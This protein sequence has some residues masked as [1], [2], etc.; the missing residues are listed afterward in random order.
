MDEIE[1]I[2]LLPRT[3]LLANRRTSSG[4]WSPERCDGG[5]TWRLGRAPAG[6]SLLSTVCAARRR[7]VLSFQIV[8]FG[9]SAPALYVGVEQ[10]AERPELME[11][12]SVINIRTR[13]PLQGVVG[14]P[15]TV[16]MRTP[17]NSP[18]LP[19]IDEHVI[20]PGPG[21]RDVVVEVLGE[22]EDWGEVEIWASLMA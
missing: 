6:R 20:E 10:S 19:R 8:A 12:P 11:F 21:L 9:G 1:R 5:N 22:P 7:V 16:W 13:K 18:D 3:R 17:R 15:W 4:F 14:N 2:D